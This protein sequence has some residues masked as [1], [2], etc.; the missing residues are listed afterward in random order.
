MPYKELTIE[1]KKKA[2][3]YVL[4]V[5]NK[6]IGKSFAETV[7]IIANRDVWLEIK[8]RHEVSR[9]L[10]Y[11]LLKDMTKKYNNKPIL[12]EDP[13]HPYIFFTTKTNWNENKE[14]IK[15]LYDVELP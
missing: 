9:H 2:A 1:E 7:R 13:D 5:L 11:G 4:P 3:E 10:V 8:R 12:E 6:F 14:L 15:K